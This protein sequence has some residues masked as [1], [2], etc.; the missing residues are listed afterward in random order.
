TLSTAA[1]TQLKWLRCCSPASWCGRRPSA[2]TGAT[3][4]DELPLRLHQG[5]ADKV[6][7][8]GQQDCQTFAEVFAWMP[9]ATLIDDR[10]LVA[11]G[12]ISTSWTWSLLRQARPA[13]IPVGLRPPG[14]DGEKVDYLE[15]RQVLDLLWSDPKPQAGCRQHVSEAAACYFGPDVTES[16]LRKNKL[17]LLSVATDAHECSRML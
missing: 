5:G 16:F 9:L 1:P 14:N 2:S 11:H 12:G 15:W 7:A 17:T 6:Q 10:I 13:Q 8:F 3:R 4:R